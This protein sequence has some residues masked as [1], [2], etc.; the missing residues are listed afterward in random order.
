MSGSVRLLPVAVLCLAALGCADARSPATGTAPVT[1]RSSVDRTAAWVGDPLT[2]TLEVVCSPGYDIVQDDLTRDR[3]PLEGLDV[4]AAST[5]RDARNDGV[6][7]YRARFQLASFTPDREGLR[8]G[9]LSIRYYRRDADWRINTQ[10][11]A[12]TVAVREEDIALRSTLP[13]SVGLVLRAAKTPTLLPSFTRVVYP[14][15][16]GL[17]ALSLVTVAFGLKGTIGRRRTSTQA[18]GPA[19]R[20]STDY[21][22]ALEE[23]RRL[24]DTTNHE[25]LRHAFGRLDHLLREF[26]GEMNIQARSLTLDEIESRVGVGGDVTPAA[27]V[28]DVLR[29]CERVRYGGPS[30]PH[31]RELLAHALDRAEKV[32]VS[33]SGDGQ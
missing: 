32:L 27:A 29:D 33:A 31:S 6:V 1:V 23:L 7:V 26:L 25:A 11:P 22:T 4:R 2:Y 16:V 15:G 12:G 13:E 24:E 3:L 20:P 17:I 28:A 30:Q 18:Q 8:I 9:P 14:L 21:R 10:L 5:T 19:R